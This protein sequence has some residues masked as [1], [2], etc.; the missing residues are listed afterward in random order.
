MLQVLC[1]LYAAVDWYNKRIH[2]PELHGMDNSFKN[3]KKTKK[4]NNNNETLS[5]IKWRELF[6]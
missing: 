3:S 5:C 4:N 2:R 1:T 6:D